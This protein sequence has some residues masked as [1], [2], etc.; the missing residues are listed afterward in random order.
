MARLTDVALPEFGLETILPEIPPDEHRARLETLTAAMADARLDLLA[1]YADREH[2][3]NLAYL[4]GFDPRFEEALLLMDARGGRLLLVGNECM[5]YLPHPSLGLPVR[6]FQEF[7]LMGQ[8]RSETPPL[9]AIL[10]DFG[11]SKRAR[12]GAV[13]WKYFGPGVVED[14]A[15]ALDLPAYL[16]DAL[17]AL[18]GE[19][20]NAGA[21]LMDPERGLRAANSADQI[22]AF[23]FAAVRTSE[24]LKAILRAL[25]EGAV[26]RDLARLF[27][28]G[29][30][31]LSCH[32]M[33]SFGEKARRG[34]SSP[35]GRPAR[36]GEAWTAA[37]GIQG[38]LTCRAGMLAHRPEDL[39]VELRG[40]YP[41]FAANY[42]DVTARWYS[43]IRVGASAG[44]VFGEADGTRDPALFDFFVNPGHLLGLEEWLHSPF[45][46]GSAVRLRSGMALQMDIIP[47]SRGPWCTVN[48]ED[49]V[50]LAD[51]TLRRVLAEG[52]PACWARIQARRRFMQEGL[53][54]AMDE[55]VL[56]LGNTTGWLAPYAL[57]PERAF[58]TGN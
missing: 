27:D 8:S 39:P 43:S 53:G 58:V 41:R 46:A 18:A 23:E 48:A 21:L 31:P 40:F 26:E 10:E 6:R 52:H 14:P 28:G 32:A 30:L 15:H 29:G 35:S 55:S 17:R 33:L 47:V 7:S 36:L 51:A 45:S 56:P 22:A 11:V 25:K 37:L 38:A 54:I 1:V 24:S 34:L 2:A 5:H 13:G 50:A 49:G 3:A 20:V 44:E 57:A 12:V 42:F 9:K 16:A 19:V 4:T